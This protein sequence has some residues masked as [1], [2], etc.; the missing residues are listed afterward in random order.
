M[1]KKIKRIIIFFALILCLSFFVTGMIKATIYT[2][3]LFT[4]D[5]YANRIYQSED[6]PHIYGIVTKQHNVTSAGVW[7]N[8]TFN[9][10]YSI[11]EGNITFSND[12]D[13]IIQETGDYIIN[14]GASILDTSASPT[15]SVGLRIKKN[16]EQLMGSYFETSTTK[17][18]AGQRISK[19]VY[20]ELDEG[21]VLTMQYISSQTTVQI[22]SL[23]T[24]NTGIQQI[25][26]GWIQRID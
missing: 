16:S 20:A 5:I 24:Y 26:Y 15:A 18:N 4:G 21:D 14:V 2:D 1:K 22:Y 13:I 7:Y 25:A 19:L 12:R 6:H 9:S 8:L 3:S 17:Q 10:T 11:V 23:N